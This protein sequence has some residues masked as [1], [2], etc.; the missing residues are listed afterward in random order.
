MTPVYSYI[1]GQGFIVEP[2]MRAEAGDA[3][4]KD[5]SLVSERNTTCR[6]TCGSHYF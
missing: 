3:S 6:G 4:P 2:V 1:T 5:H